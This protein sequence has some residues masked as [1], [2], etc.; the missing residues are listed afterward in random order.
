MPM[1]LYSE[2]ACD[3]CGKSH[4]SRRRW[5]SR[6]QI[7]R[8][9]CKSCGSKVRFALEEVRW[10]CRQEPDNQARTA[11]FASPEE[12]V[13]ELGGQSASGPSVRPPVEPAASPVERTTAGRRGRQ[14]GKLRRRPRTPMPPIP[15]RARYVVYPSEMSVP[16]L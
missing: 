12:V 5:D 3:R 14:G 16:G 6:Q 2:I 9:T 1:M 11:Y 7:Y 13:P 8:F 15:P 4:R 10:I